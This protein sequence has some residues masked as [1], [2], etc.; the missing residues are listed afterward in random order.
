M[1]ASLKTVALI[2]ALALAG[3]AAPPQ[4]RPDTPSGRPEVM[5]SAPKKQVLDKLVAGLVAEGMSLKSA[6]DYTAVFGKRL[7][8]N[9]AASLLYGSRYDSVPELRVTFTTIE[10]GASTRVFGNAAV[11]TNS[12]S[13]YE[14][15]QD[16]TTQNGADMQ[17][18]LER[19]RD[20]F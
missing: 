13:A 7:E 5:I 12:G 17:R 6:N 11:V 16:V 18:I 9:F 8:G 2:S 10:S 3:C 1:L 4:Y 15:V 19:L 14:R 20:G